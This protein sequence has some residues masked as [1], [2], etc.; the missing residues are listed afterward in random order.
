VVTGAAGFIGSRVLKALAELH[1]AGHLLAVDHPLTA[2]KQSNLAVASA[3]PYLD[4][5]EFIRALESDKLRPKIIF[6]MGA[7]SST[8]ES[9]WTYLLNNNLIYSQRLWS[10]CASHGGRLIYASSAATYGDGAQGFDDEMDIRLLQPLNL[11]GKSKQDFDL[12]VEQQSLAAPTRP[13]QCVGLKFFNVYGPG[14]SHK[15]RMASMVFHGWNQ[16]RQRG[17]VQLFK[18]YKE[19]YGDGGQLR[20]FIYV[21]EVVDVMLSFSA[22]PGVSGL[23]NLGT[24][25][26]RSFNEL[27]E[28]LFSAIGQEPRIEYIPM[29]GDLIGK[30]QYYTEATMSKLARSG[31]QY[32][33]APLREAVADYAH[34]LGQNHP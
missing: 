17:F 29:P 1:P 6:H 32:T 23:F 4:H 28:A 5:E 8:T 21:K 10:W 16:I 34:W 7:C 30:Y 27:I 33:P 12:W 31:I 25:H 9:N 2:E 13:V 14:E 18:S 3:V 11:Y 24:G 22:Q 15:G 20:D 19:G 26:A